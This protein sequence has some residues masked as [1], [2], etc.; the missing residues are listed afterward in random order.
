MKNNETK[1]IWTAARYIRENGDVLDFT[2]LYEVSD[3]GRVRSM[4]Y[5]GTGKVRELKQS[6]P[7]AKNGTI[8]YQ[9]VLCK[10]GKTYSLP[11]HRLVLSSFRPEGHPKGYSPNAVADHINPREGNDCCNLLSNLRWFTRRDNVST[12][13]CKDLLSNTHTNH[14]SLS[15]QVRVTLSD[16]TYMLFPSANEAE[17]SMD[18]PYNTIN[19]YIKKRKGYYKKRQLHF[20]YVL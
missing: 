18:L 12:D 5:H 17:R 15:K 4:N 16:G 20:E 3:Q 13:H 19:Q 8:W 11:T 1:E 14:P 2:G 7:K 6:T 10:N 9:V